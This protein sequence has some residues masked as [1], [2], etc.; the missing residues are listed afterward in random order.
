[1]NGNDEHEAPPDD[2]TP[3]GFGGELGLFYCGSRARGS[4]QA[5][6]S[7]TRYAIALVAGMLVG[8]G[9]GG[10][11]AAPADDHLIRTLVG[12]TAELAGSRE[13]FAS[14]FAEGSVPDEATRN[15]FRGM[16]TRLDSARVD[17]AGATATAQVEFEVLETG[18]QLG[19]V[20]WTLAKSG[21]EWKVKTV[22]VPA[23]D[24]R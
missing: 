9:D 23:G 8:C 10:T 19:P 21:D 4:A 18:E 13:G 2:S 22:E 15:K 16:M 5:V 17:E 6:M 1:V 3:Y 14:C 12:H 24:S 11:A 7:N 20:T